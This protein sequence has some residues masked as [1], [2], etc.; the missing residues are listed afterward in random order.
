MD[1]APLWNLHQ[2][3][4]EQ[5]LAAEVP[6]PG[7]QVLGT[8][9]V[10]ER[11]M[12]RAVRWEPRSTREPA[13]L[14][15]R[16][17]ED[18]SGALLRRLDSFVA[19]MHA[20]PMPG[21]AVPLDYGSTASGR[22]Y[23]TTELFDRD[24]ARL[25]AALQPALP[26]LL[27][28][29]ARVLASMHARRMV[30]GNLQPGNVLIKEHA[31]SYNIALCDPAIIAG[32][33]TGGDAS[34]DLRAW[35]RL[36][37]HAYGYRVAGAGAQPQ[38]LVPARP[39]MPVPM[40][41]ALADIVEHALAAGGAAASP[42]LDTAEELVH[43]LEALVV[44][45][46]GAV[47][48]MRL[49]VGSGPT[50]S[51]SAH[52]RRAL[53]RAGFDVLACVGQGAAATV[54]RVRRGGREHAAKVLHGPRA[55]ARLA[56]VQGVRH[57]LP[58]AGDVPLALPDELGTLPTGAAFY[59]MEA[60]AGTL[61]E[62]AGELDP[63]AIF[64]ILGDVAR[65]LARLHRVG[66]VHRAIKPSNVLLARG[67]A[68]YRVG[69]ADFEHALRLVDGGAVSQELLG[70][71]EPPPR[72]AAP[73]SL[74]PAGD[75]WSWATTALWALSRR[76]P[77]DAGAIEPLV[78]RAYLAARLPELPAALVDLL[79][80]CLDQDTG[81]R[82]SAD[83]VAVI[84]AREVARRRAPGPILVAPGAEPEQPFPAL[85]A[86]T[87]AE[88][89][90][91]HG[92]EHDVAVV[93]HMVAEHRLV[94]L[95]GRPGAGKSSFLAAGLVPRLEASGAAG[96][97]PYRAIHMQPGPRPFAALAAALLAAPA[98]FQER[99]ARPSATHVANLAAALRKR[100][101][102]A[103]WPHLDSGHAR[104]LLIVDQGEELLTTV[105]D[106]RE[107]EAFAALL[108]DALAVN[109]GPRSLAIVLAVR[110]DFYGPL[111]S[112]PVLAGPALHHAHYLRPFGRAGLQVVIERI[113]ER[114]GYGWEAGLAATVAAQAE[115]SGC[116][117]PMLHVVAAELWL[118]RDRAARRITREA[119]AALGGSEGAVEQH[120]ER[121]L[122]ALVADEELWDGLDAGGHDVAARLAARR[123]CLDD[124]V[125]AV[126]LCLMDRDQGLQRP[127]EAS[128]LLQPFA[129][130]TV[131]RSLAERVLPHLVNGRLL[132]CRRPG[133]GALESL[134][135]TD[136]VA[137]VH[138]A[139]IAGWPTLRRW[140]D[141][142]RP[143]R[144]L[145]DEIRARAEQWEAGGRA[146]R[147]LW[148]GARV[149]QVREGLARYR[150]SL[151]A[152]EAAF[153]QACERREHARRQG[154]T[155]LVV[156]AT[157]IG[158][159]GIAALL[160]LG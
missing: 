19:H 118:R 55:M 20:A 41:P 89:D 51:E 22:T 68:G 108:R 57:G 103:L 9:G 74:A 32:K 145:L 24:L 73:G 69:V 93:S 23:Y 65:A 66:F 36:A 113:A 120:L 121:L 70:T 48:R 29:V 82:P 28:D 39:G 2:R 34:A 155:L 127:A 105:A 132:A 115:D 1:R 53:T 146:R 45:D 96:E 116:A 14:A 160:L 78:D 80:R 126:L 100:G 17:V 123:A 30:H 125:R 83:E 138:E 71:L 46:T 158:A 107:R 142:E 133:Q 94:V 136:T 157:V 25:P 159:A 56:C 84:V 91:L 27:A 102:A 99:H 76:C 95:V 137:L 21:L 12:L 13:L 111:L 7:L 26:A 144:R 59:T 117:L 156:T 154:Y 37:A 43:A 85:A 119:F 52:A 6:L 153:W 49:A 147:A 124:V 151:R 38:A 72:G 112:L 130:G 44:T 75:V 141:E 88:R 114:H 31:A 42:L 63:I 81:V 97:L 128:E 10:S 15:L 131:H 54:F 11:G 149:R 101:C 87:T 79:A 67:G 64:E 90:C 3:Q 122:G 62:R 139:L 33:D 140:L 8:L 106:P 92:R 134:A 152:T 109:A 129:P 18:P 61:R 5:A 86:L 98:G 35:G 58:D 135:P 60:F 47:P 148:T 104:P 150:V 110:D 50:R 40:P 77:D 143:R 4:P 16:V